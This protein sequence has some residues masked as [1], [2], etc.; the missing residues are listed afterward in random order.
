MHAILA[1]LL[2]AD[3]SGA[4]DA[5]VQLG[6]P[7]PWVVVVAPVP[8]RDGTPSGVWTT[9]WRDRSGTRWHGLLVRTGPLTLDERSAGNPVARWEMRPDGT[10][11]VGEWVLKR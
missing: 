9:E 11:A 2:L 10:I 4:W 8:H 1:L 3:P 6:H 7:Q 5:H